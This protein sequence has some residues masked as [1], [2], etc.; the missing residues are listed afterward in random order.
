MICELC[1]DHVTWR[2]PLVALTHTECAKCGGLNCQVPEHG[3]DDSEPND[4]GEDF[5]RAGGGR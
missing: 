1:G 2:G 4:D 3:E 5:E